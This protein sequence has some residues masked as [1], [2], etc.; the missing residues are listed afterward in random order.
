MFSNLFERFW[1]QIKS[2]RFLFFV[3]LIAYFCV[4]P[5]GVWAMSFNPEFDLGDSVSTMCYLVVPFMSTW[6]IFMVLKEYIDGDGREVLLLGRGTLFS[7]VLFQVINIV[8]FVP[9]FFVPMKDTFKSDMYHLFIQLLII[10][11]F[12]GGLTY[13]CNYFT[14]S[15]TISM[16]IAILYTAVSNYTFY[17][18]H[19]SKMFGFVQLN[20]LKDVP[21]EDNL[22]GYWKFITAGAAFWVLGVIRSR[23]L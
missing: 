7:A 3:P 8:C 17:N 2:M 5:L 6:W 11:F 13:F 16:L 21:C 20:T 10:S 12:M 23:K 15:I 18:E 22:A 1:L 14:G 19:L 4:I 9:V